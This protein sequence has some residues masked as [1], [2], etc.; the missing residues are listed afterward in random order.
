MGSHLYFLP[1]HD[2]LLKHHRYE[3]G[4]VLWRA[5]VAEGGGVVWCWGRL[6]PLNHQYYMG[7]DDG[8][9]IAIFC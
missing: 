5:D 8:A 2:E 1:L 3:V 7:V 9:E 4:R 6:I